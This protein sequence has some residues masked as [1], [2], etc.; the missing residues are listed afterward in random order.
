MSPLFG[1]EAYALAKAS[2]LLQV[3]PGNLVGADPLFRQM[4]DL[5]QTSKDRLD[6]MVRA[7]RGFGLGDI[8]LDVFQTECKVLRYEVASAGFFEVVTSPLKKNGE[9]SK[10]ELRFHIQTPLTP[11]PV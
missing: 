10:R 1:K 11:K 5:A 2:E 6:A 4:L 9:L 3:L 8:V 7:E